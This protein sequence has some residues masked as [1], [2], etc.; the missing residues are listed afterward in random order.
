VTTRPPA[1]RAA[2]AAGTSGPQA[3]VSALERVTARPVRARL[4]RDQRACRGAAFPR[5][6]TG[7][8]L[9]PAAGAPS[10]DV[11]EMARPVC[12]S[13]CGPRSTRPSERARPSCT[14][15]SSWKPT[16]TPSGSTCWCVPSRV[17][18]GC[19]TVPRR[20]PGG[21][22]T[23]DSRRGRCGRC[24]GPV[25]C[26]QRDQAARE[27]APHDEGSPAGN[28]RGGRDLQ[29]GAEN[30]P[31]RS[32]SRPTRSCSR[33]TKS[34]RPPRRSCSRSIEELETINA[35]LNGKVR[36]LD[37]ANSDLLNLFQATRIPTCS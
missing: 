16:A 8:Y 27:R 31:T 6:R 17:G 24:G 4:G 1:A 3:L 37:Q 18:G 13:T 12:G 19:R 5:A 2:I 21:R 9:E 26:R 10:A 36:E 33:P 30:P 35:E 34:C 25:A 23:T 22:P 11:V 15:T 14:R 29:R 32:S 20:V 7:K 28:G